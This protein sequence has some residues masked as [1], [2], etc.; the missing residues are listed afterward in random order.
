M[1]PVFCHV[2]TF[3]MQ[4]MYTSL[5]PR[6][7][8]PP[9]FH[10]FQYEIRRGKAWEI[11][12]RAMTSGRQMVDTREAVPNLYN[13]CFAVICLCHCEQQ[14]VSIVCLANALIS[15]HWM[16]SATQDVEIL[17]WA[18]PSVCLPCVYLMASHVTR[19]PRH[20]ISSGEILAAGMV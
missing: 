8:P 1:R 17:R 5:V 9:V 16:D 19:S 18:P 12:S 4:C 3:S 14:M 11:W 15:S 6:P 2:C 13:T 20:R 10:R 7:F